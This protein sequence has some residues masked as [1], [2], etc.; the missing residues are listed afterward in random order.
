MKKL[1]LSLVSLA[2]L[3]VCAGCNA[4]AQDAA[5]LPV[6]TIVGTMPIPS[7]SQP[8]SEIPSAVQTANST[9]LA[10]SQALD[11]SSFMNQRL[12][13]VYVNEVQGNPYQMDVNY[14]GFTAS[15]LLGTPQGLSVYMDGVRM[16]QPFGDVVSWDLMPRSAI[17]NMT[18]MPGSNTLTLTGGGTVVVSYRAAYL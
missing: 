6:V 12:G 5:E 4:W 18:L 7:I 13:G 15:P 11:L 9:D 2:V 17:A 10:N 3:S 16:N 8:L 1:R 14:R